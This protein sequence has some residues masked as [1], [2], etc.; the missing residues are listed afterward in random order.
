MAVGGTILLTL[1]GP[2]NYDPCGSTDYENSDSYYAADTRA[3]L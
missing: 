2:R 1:T 3:R